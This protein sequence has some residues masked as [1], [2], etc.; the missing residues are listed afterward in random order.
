MALLAKLVKFENKS[1]ESI[2]F[3]FK[4]GNYSILTVPSGNLFIFLPMYLLPTLF[5]I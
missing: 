5:V 2:Y 4:T 3:E 1:G